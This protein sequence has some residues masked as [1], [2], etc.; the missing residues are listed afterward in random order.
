MEEELPLQTEIIPT[1]PPLPTGLMEFDWRTSSIAWETKSDHSIRSERSIR[2]DRSTRA[3][4][5]QPGLSR[6]EIITDNLESIGLSS[7][8][9]L[10]FRCESIFGPRSW[11]QKYFQPF[12]RIIQINFVEM[13]SKL[14]N[15][16]KVVSMSDV[17][18][19]VKAVGNSLAKL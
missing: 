14:W 12:Q 5:S 19:L 3:D 9:Q 15:N 7:D 10:L 6:Q 16:M 8:A 18:R 17:M 1:A 13:R 11:I 4:E 2:S